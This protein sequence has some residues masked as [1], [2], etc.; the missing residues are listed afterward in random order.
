M[1]EQKS[2]F[3]FSMIEGMMPMYPALAV[4]GWMFVLVAFLVGWFM[5]SPTQSTFFSDAKA[6]R[7]GALVCIAGP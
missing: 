4:M 7:E 2:S 5:L 6:I 3:P 1:Q